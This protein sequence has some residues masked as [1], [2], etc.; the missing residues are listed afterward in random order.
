MELF[1]GNSGKIF[2]PANLMMNYADLF[3]KVEYSIISSSFMNS[4]NCS[5]DLV[6]SVND[7]S[8][9][10]CALDYDAKI[11]SSSLSSFRCYRYFPMTVTHSEIQYDLY[12]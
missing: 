3:W 2:N 10:Y 4:K 5:K 9:Q 1:L 6:Q 8:F 11:Y 7:F 12:S